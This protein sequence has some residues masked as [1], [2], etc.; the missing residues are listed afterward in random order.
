MDKI[1]T[2]SFVSRKPAASI[3]SLTSEQKSKLYDKLAV[4][5]KNSKFSPEEIADSLNKLEGSVKELLDMFGPLDLDEFTIRKWLVNVINDRIDNKGADLSYSKDLN[6]LSWVKIGRG[7]LYDLMNANRKDMG[8][9]SHSPEHEVTE[10]A[11]DRLFGDSNGEYDV[12]WDAVGLSKF[13][14]TMKKEV[15]VFAGAV[16]SSAL[17]KTLQLFAAKKFILIDKNEMAGRVRTA[18]YNLGIKNI[19]D[20]YPPSKDGEVNGNKENRDKLLKNIKLY[21]F[22]DKV[23]K[24][25]PNIVNALILGDNKDGEKDRPFD[26]F[27]D[28]RKSVLFNSFIRVLISSGKMDEYGRIDRN[29]GTDENEILYMA[30]LATLS[31][32]GGLISHL[33]ATDGNADAVYDIDFKNNK[34]VMKAF[35]A[36]IIDDYGLKGWT[37]ITTYGPDSSLKDQINWL[38]KP[39]EVSEEVER[40]DTPPEQANSAQPAKIAAPANDPAADL[41]PPASK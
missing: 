16:S 35:L 6:V 28:D 15:F 22:G 32:E 17:L 33:E 39:E 7:E 10:Q 38:K 18:L 36:T 25:E 1:A 30:G 31:G 27:K 29:N 12:K 5:M 19:E 13:I 3:G 9:F 34:D 11:F 41:P 8:L 23:N 40:V 21:V 24:T 14:R 20:E 4:K 37:G 2:P 26:Y